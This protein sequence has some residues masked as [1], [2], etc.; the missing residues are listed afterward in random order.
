LQVV[1]NAGEP[2]PRAEVI[3]SLDEYSFDE[4]EPTG[5]TNRDGYVVIQVPTLDTYHAIANTFV[6]IDPD[7]DYAF[8]EFYGMASGIQ[9]DCV[10][11]GAQQIQGT[12]GCA[13]IGIPSWNLTVIDQDTGEHICNATV[14]E[15]GGDVVTSEDLGDGCS[16]TGYGGD[17]FELSIEAP[18]Y[19]SQSIEGDALVGAMGAHCIYRTAA[20]L[21]VELVKEP[22]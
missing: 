5:T 10:D 14:S 4:D 12:W 2:V 17:H 13:A 7:L 11:A 16:Y 9:S 1:D 19:A 15:E 6:Q 18:G 22:D 21:T 20:T 3:L 8:E